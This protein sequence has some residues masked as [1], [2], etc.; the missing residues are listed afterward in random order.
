MDVP[1]FIYLKGPPTKEDIRCLL[2]E[3]ADKGASSKTIKLFGSLS[4]TPPAGRLAIGIAQATS[5]LSEQPIHSIL[6]DGVLQE[7]RDALLELDVLQF[8]KRARKTARGLLCVKERWIFSKS[9]RGFFN[10]AR[11]DNESYFNLGENN[12]TS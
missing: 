12:G 1:E 11:A 8:S 9:V 4:L 10:R 7:E 5:I 6:E 3:L 2:T